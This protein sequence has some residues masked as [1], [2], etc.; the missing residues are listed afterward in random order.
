MVLI[1]K[2]LLLTIISVAL[3][4]AFAT[5][6]SIGEAQEALLKQS[7]ALIAPND[8]SILADDDKDK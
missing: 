5:A 2:S 1:T 6:K 4:I 3:Q 7:D 8:V